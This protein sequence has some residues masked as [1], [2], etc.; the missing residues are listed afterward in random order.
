M[1]IVY[2]RRLL[3]FAI[4]GLVIYLALG[5]GSRNFE[6]YCPFGGV[7][8]LYSFITARE[9]TCALSPLN[10]SLFLAVLGLT[11]FS[12]KSFCGYLCP[13]GAISEW[14]GWLSRKIFRRTWEPD[15]RTMLFLKPI[16][17][18]IL[19]LAIW[20]TIHTGELILRGYDPFYPIFSGFGEGTLGWITWLMLGLIFAT[21]FF[22]VMPWCRILCPLGAVL[23]PFSR[24]G[25]LRLVHRDDLCT[26]CGKCDR[27]CPQ[28]LPVTAKPVLTY[29]DCTNC[30]NCTD[31][32]PEKDALQLTFLGRKP[33]K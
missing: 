17:Y 16:R 6:N 25:L 28:R 13:I 30:L 4:L 23:D 27:A 14:Q 3:Q 7:E 8:A 22:L 1:K 24:I 19:V 2:V 11:L 29:P 33:R 10:L 18:L 31:V 20:G 21:G 12:K 32:C 5:Y 26:H 9:F 15:R